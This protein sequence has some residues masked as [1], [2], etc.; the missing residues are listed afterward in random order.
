M[1]LHGGHGQYSLNAHVKLPMTYYQP[2][3]HIS[4]RTPHYPCGPVSPCVFPFYL[5]DVCVYTMIVYVVLWF[6]KVLWQACGGQ[7]TA[8]GVSPCPPPCLE[9]GSLLIIFFLW[10]TAFY[11]YLPYPLSYRHTLM[12]YVSS[13]E[14][15]FGSYS[16]TA[17]SLPTEP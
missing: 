9:A 3:S 14:L 7:G 8:S 2:D 5:F 13:R 1:S 17:S 4:L 10:A 16:C 12:L 6:I 11:F 15:N